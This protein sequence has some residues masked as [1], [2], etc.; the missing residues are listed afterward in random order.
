MDSQVDSV[1]PAGLLLLQH[2]RFVLVIEE[3]DDGLPRI[4]VVDVVAEARRIDDCQFD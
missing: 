1:G 2:I 4:G 3:F